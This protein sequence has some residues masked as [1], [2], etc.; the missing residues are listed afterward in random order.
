MQFL[1]VALVLLGDPGTEVVATRLPAA[2][3]T[4]VAETVETGTIIASRGASVAVRVSTFSRYTHVGAVVMRDGQPVVYDS[5]IRIGVRCQPLDE[6][7]ESQRPCEI[8]LFHPN[9]PFTKAQAKSFEKHLHQQLGRPY[10]YKQ[11][12]TGSP[13]AGLHCAE[14]VTGA[15]IAGDQ[16]TAENPTRVSPGE[17]LECVTEHALY[18]TSEKLSLPAVPVPE[19]PRSAT[20]YG[21]AW[22]DTKSCTQGCWTQTK[23]WVWSK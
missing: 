4:A 20:W 16:I 8:E 1:M 21:R 10:S 3:V 23:R 12:V 22:Q 15:L 2:T 19:A 9:R 13:C 11:Y 14:Y 17:I 5:M 18:S 6:Y 7:L